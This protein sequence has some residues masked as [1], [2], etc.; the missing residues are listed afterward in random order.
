MTTINLR[1]YYSCY[2]SD[3]YI[4]VPDEVA[5]ALAD[6]ER[7][8]R[9]YI[10]RRNYNNAVYSLDAGDGIEQQALFFAQSADELYERWMTMQQF[11]SALDA[12]PDMQGRRLYAHYI[13]GYTQT[14]IAK[15]E[16]I[17][18]SAVNQSIDCGLKS[19]EKLL[20]NIF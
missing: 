2:H 9:N 14:E 4:E 1:D 12:L 11:Y 3:F 20:K 15:S 13:L 8:E 17:S 16:G 19:L 5:A 18:I 10:R 6:A 7:M